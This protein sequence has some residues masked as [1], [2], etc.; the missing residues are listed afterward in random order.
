VQVLILSALWPEPTSSAAGSRMMQ[1]IHI[2]IQENWS[3]CYASTANRSP[4]SENLGQLGVQT[5]TILLNDAS[6]DVFIQKMKP[7]LVL[8][9]RFMLEE[10][11]G[12]RVAE[13]CPN[14]LRVLDSEDLHGLRKAREQAIKNGKPF[15]D[16]DLLSD[17][18]FREIASIYR[19]D[20]T[21]IISQHELKLL[22][23]F[24][25]VPKALLLYLPFLLGEITKPLMRYK[26]RKHFITIGNFLHP[27]NWDAVRH[28]KTTIWPL[29]RKQLSNAQLLVYGAYPS[30]KVTQLHNPEE[31]FLIKGRAESAQ[32]VLQDARVLLAPLRFGAGLKG[33]L[34]DAMCYGTP[35]TTTTIG[36]EGIAGELP[37]GGY[38]EDEVS[39]FAKAAVGLY[40]DESLWQKAQEAGIQIINTRFLKTEF[41]TIFISC[42]Q[43]LLGNLKSHRQANFTGAM[44]FHHTL[45]SSKYLGKW[46]ETKNKD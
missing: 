27:P 32:E 16:R 2:C 29:I 6:F 35:N 7:D 23:T 15:S 13:H 22:E 21:L 3:V 5:A 43:T 42:I 38:V 44:L 33:K 24:F 41:E 45:Q 14:A 46:I 19:C 4:H 26:D 31:G 17:V 20:L 30:P 34:I 39:A 1:L 12:W 40:S 37:W 11:F 36:A 18:A 9:D 10:Q 28:L 8:F 25:K